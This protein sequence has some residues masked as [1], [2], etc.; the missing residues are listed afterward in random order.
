MKKWLLIILGFFILIQ[1]IRIDQE[2]PKIDYGK[3]FT[4]N[5]ATPATIKTLVKRSCY[6]CHSF[7]TT[8]HWY[9]NVAPVSWWIKD[10]VN[11]GREYINFSTWEDYSN[12]EKA[13]KLMNS[14]AYIKPD[15]MPLTTY[16]SQHPEAKLSN[17]EKEFLVE[18]MTK[19]AEKY[20]PELKKDK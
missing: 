18:W 10:H 11:E 3:D 15:Q 9:A 6:A 16:V 17:D 13:R 20:Y 8:Y 4:S 12:E 14:V 19:E 7:E 5:N 1:F 2:K